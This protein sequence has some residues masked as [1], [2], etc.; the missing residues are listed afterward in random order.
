MRLKITGI[1][2]FI[3]IIMLAGTALAVD[4]D[5]LD[6]VSVLMPQ[7]K[8]HSLLGSPDEIISLGKGLTA[9]LYKVTNAEPMIGTGCIYQDNQQLVAQAFIYKGIANKEAAARLVHDGYNVL[10]ETEGVFRLAGKDDDTGQPL[11][12]RISTENGMTMIMTFEK[13]FYDSWAK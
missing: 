3:L 10:E 12:A 2:V 5:T 8:V 4:I 11:V 9:E 6:K 13:H 7:S 1:S